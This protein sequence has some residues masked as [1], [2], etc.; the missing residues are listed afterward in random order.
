[1]ELFNDIHKDSASYLCQPYQVQA[2]KQG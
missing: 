1:M 2:Y